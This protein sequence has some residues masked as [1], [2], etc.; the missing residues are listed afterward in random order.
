MLGTSDFILISLFTSRTPSAFFSK[1]V[2]DF[3]TF[4]SE[5]SGGSNL[6]TGEVMEAVS[7]GFADLKVTALAVVALAV[8]ATMGVLGVSAA[9]KYA[10]KKAKGALNSAA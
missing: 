10:I 8:G 4:A 5:S 9:A 1:R 6:L 7:G 2:L 3:V